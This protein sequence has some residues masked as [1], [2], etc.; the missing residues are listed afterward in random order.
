MAKQDGSIKV[1]GSFLQNKVYVTTKENLNIFLGHLKLYL[2]QAKLFLNI[3]WY[4]ENYMW[5][6]TSHLLEKMYFPCLLKNELNVS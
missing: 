6:K 3:V 4:F 2:S 1:L 5:Y